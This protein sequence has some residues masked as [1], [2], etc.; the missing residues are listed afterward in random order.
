MAK[1][2]NSLFQG[3]TGRVGE[4]VVYQRMGQ[5]CMRKHVEHIRDARSEEQ[6]R[7]HGV[8]RAMMHTASAM[9]EALAVGLRRAA[10]EAGMVD[11]NAFLRL[12][13]QCFS[14]DGTGANVAVDYPSL[15]LAAGPVA[16]VAF[17]RARVEEGR[18]EGR[19]DR[20]GGPGLNNSADHVQ[21]YAYCPAREAGFLSLPVYRMDRRISFVLPSWMAGEEVHFYAFCTSMED[22]TLASASCYLEVEET[23]AEPTDTDVEPTATDTASTAHGNAPLRPSATPLGATAHATPVEAPQGASKPPSKA[24]DG[25]GAARPG[26]E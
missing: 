23:D 13:S 14:S 11:S 6:L 15:T 5:W 1:L 17:T 7:Q 26:S 8:F 10:R 24:D 12:N 4:V 22:R 20:V 2:H 19:F 16:P 25:A 9:K 21:V 18:F 3:V